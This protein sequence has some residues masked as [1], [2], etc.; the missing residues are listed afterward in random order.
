MTPT[1]EDLQFAAEVSWRYHQRR[2]A[3]FCKVDLVIN[4]MTVVTSAGAFLFLLGGDRALVV[5]VLSA[6]VTLLTLTQI[7]CGVGRAAVKHE[8]WYSEW[9]ELLAE[10][11]TT[12]SPSQRQLGEWIRRRRKIETEYPHELRALEV[13]C[14]N[15]AIEALGLDGAELRTIAWWQKPILHIVSVQ[16]KFPHRMVVRE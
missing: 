3:F 16:S 14:R 2:A 9:R 10:M 1:K 11:Q 6:T 4:W 5:Q 8:C 15:D 12:T 13:D 7:V